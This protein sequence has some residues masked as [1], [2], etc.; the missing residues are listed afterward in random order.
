MHTII[1]ENK[2]AATKQLSAA[3]GYRE[4]WF[5]KGMIRVRPASQI[6]IRRNPDGT[7]DEIVGHSH[8]FHLE[9]MGDGHWFLIIG[10][11][12]VNFTSRGKIKVTAHE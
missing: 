8:F 1:A 2:R 9:Q 4:T 10:D 12:R 6:E 3:L 11:Q 5:R 7:P